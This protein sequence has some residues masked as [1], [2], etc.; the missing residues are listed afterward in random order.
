M[1]KYVKANFKVFKTLLLKCVKAIFKANDSRYAT[2][3]TSFNEI[4][5]SIS[6][7]SLTTLN[8]SSL[9]YVQLKVRTN[10]ELKSKFK[11][12]HLGHMLTVTKQNNGLYVQNASHIQLFTKISKF[13]EKSNY[14][15]TLLLIINFIFRKAF[16]QPFTEFG[17]TLTENNAIELGSFNSHRRVSISSKQIIPNQLLL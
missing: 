12:P 8:W 4:T 13:S 3:T 1:L 11:G 9:L 14:L 7:A 10:N 5:T 15:K 6:A 2:M 17:L 16:Q